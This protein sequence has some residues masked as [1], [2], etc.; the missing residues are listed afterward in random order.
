MNFSYFSLSIVLCIIFIGVILLFNIVCIV[1]GD[2][3]DIKPTP[4]LSN[5][6]GTLSC[7]EFTF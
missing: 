5:L 4:F 1:V 2:V 7:L 6:T 3:P